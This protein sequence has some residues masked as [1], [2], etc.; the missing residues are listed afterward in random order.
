MVLRIEAT[1]VAGYHIHL[2]LLFNGHKIRKD[3]H[4]AR[5]IGDYWEKNIT[6]GAGYYHNVNANW[7]CNDKNYG[8]G[9]IEAADM[10]KRYNLVN[11]VM[12]YLCKSRQAVLTLPYEG[13]NTFGAGFT[14]RDRAKGRGRPRTKGAE[15][16][17]LGAG[18]RYP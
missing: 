6:K 7:D 3:V 16:Q 5:K 1:P 10:R 17:S 11:H 14:H 18:V 4:W 13:C 12:A 2:I 15:P 8:I 9:M